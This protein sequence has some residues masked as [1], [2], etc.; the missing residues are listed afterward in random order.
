MKQRRYDELIEPGKDGIERELA[1]VRSATKLTK[2]DYHLR[3]HGHQVG[4]ESLNKFSREG[5]TASVWSIDGRLRSGFVCHNPRYLP[6]I[7]GEADLVYRK[8]KFF[9]FQTVE[10]PEEN[11]KDVEEFIGV[12]FGVNNIATLS[13][14]IQYNS[15]QLD[16]VRNRYSRTRQSLQSKGTSGGRKCLKRLKGREARFATVTNHA[17][18]KQVVEK[19]K[20]LNMGIALEDLT[21]IRERTKVRKVQRRKH[22]SWA[23]AQLRFFL[24]YKARLAGIPF[25]MVNPRY[26]SQTCNICK[27]IGHRKGPSFSCPNCGNISDSDV[28]A[29]KNIAQLGIAVT[30]PDRGSMIC[31]IPLMP[32]QLAAG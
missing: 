32:C 10:I 3:V 23:F 29:A 17:I 27:M 6:H 24:Q 18:A 9:L 15:K 8:G 20:S 2:P 25:V 16:K 5:N 22:H 13:D 19:A 14:G 26:T 4:A 30:D 12:D 7:K 31:S 1:E 21:G 11:I 28:N